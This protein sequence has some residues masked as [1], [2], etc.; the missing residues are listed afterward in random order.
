MR[1]VL[2]SLAQSHTQS[3]VLVQ[4]FLDCGSFVGQINAEDFTLLCQVCNIFAQLVAIKRELSELLIFVGQGLVIRL[5]LLDFVL[6]ERYD[7][8]IASKCTTKVSTL[9]S[10]A[11]IHHA[12][13]SLH[14]AESVIV[15]PEGQSQFLR[16]AIVGEQ[17][18]VLVTEVVDHVFILQCALRQRL[19][20]LGSL[21]CFCQK[22]R[23]GVLLKQVLLIRV[24]EL[25][26]IEGVAHVSLPMLL[27][28]RHEVELMADNFSELDKTS[29]P[30]KHFRLQV[31][32]RAILVL[33][34]GNATG[35]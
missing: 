13:Q 15:S 19:E 25:P 14:H 1:R 17:L 24:E 29:P 6:R 21:D 26:F 30:V 35:E 4:Q 16:L 11:V 32:F 12:S 5:K 18:L 27:S 33:Y 20:S 9:F 3:L 34:S 8:D 23:S 2:L 31:V 22:L 7:V 10:I 28:V